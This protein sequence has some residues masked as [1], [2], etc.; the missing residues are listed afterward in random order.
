VAETLPLF[1]LGTVLFPGLLLPLHIFEQR[2]RDLVRDLVALPDDA[3]RRFGVV[4]I[5]QGWEVGDDAVSALYEVGCTAVLRRVERYD[6]G[7]FDVVAVGGDR[8][9]LSGVDPEA[10]SYLSGTVEWL[11][12][13]DDDDGAGPVLA[14]SVRTVF[15]DYLRAMAATGDGSAEAVGESDLPEDPRLLS[16]LVAATALL[17]L[18]DRQSLLAAA[19][20]VSRL[21][22][23]LR[24]LKRETTMLRRLRIVPAPLAQLA[25]ALGSN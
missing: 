6:D 14:T 13:Q 24:L 19:G 22:A 4:A 9:R 21:R 25:V 11:P 15:G 12:E 23:E 2:Y 18:D 1:P 3:P 5:R 16:H 20:T 10:H 17:D 8:F 7:R